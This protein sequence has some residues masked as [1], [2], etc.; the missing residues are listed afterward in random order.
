MFLGLET[1]KHGND[2]LRLGSSG[3]GSSAS[4]LG[5]ENQNYLPY[6][7]IDYNNESK[8]QISISIIGLYSWRGSATHCAKCFHYNYY[9][10]WIKGNKI[11]CASWDATK[12]LM[13]YA[14]T[15]SLGAIHCLSP[16][17]PPQGNIH[18]W[19]W[20][21]TDC[22]KQSPFWSQDLGFYT[23][24]SRSTAPIVWL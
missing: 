2:S 18:K 16:L 24:S 20:K 12:T 19:S 10:I 7:W 6:F 14:P 5:W 23:K 17:P 22:F 21:G 3:Q 11:I 13:T 15:C 9:L 1:Q 8:L 4:F